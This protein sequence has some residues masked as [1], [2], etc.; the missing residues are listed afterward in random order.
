MLLLKLDGRFWLNEVIYKLV[1]SI[2]TKTM[3]NYAHVYKI[4]IILTCVL[5]NGRMGEKPILDRFATTAFSSN[6]DM[7]KS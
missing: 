2:P 4:F 5:E 3:L 7:F 6:M 1:F